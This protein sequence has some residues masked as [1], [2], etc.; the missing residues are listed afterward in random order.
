MGQIALVGEG[1]TLA[2]K[3]SPDMI[4]DQKTIYRSAHQYLADGGS[5]GTDNQ[6]EDS[7]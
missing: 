2:L 6:V 7:S 5:R 1:G 4:H 3:P